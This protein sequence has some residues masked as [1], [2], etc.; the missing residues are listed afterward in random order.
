MPVSP[1]SGRTMV[2]AGLQRQDPLTLGLEERGSRVIHRPGDPILLPNPQLSLPGDFSHVGSLFLRLVLR[3]V[4]S[5]NICCKPAAMCVNSP[6]KPSRL[7][8]PAARMNSSK[9]HLGPDI[10][11]A[12]HD[13]QHLRGYSEKYLPR[14]CLASLC[15]GRHGRA[16]PN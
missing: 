4:F 15:S 10:M 3:C 9:Y 12:V 13:T 8:A 16:S 6:I 11:P 5:W 1:L 14:Y 2:V 7:L